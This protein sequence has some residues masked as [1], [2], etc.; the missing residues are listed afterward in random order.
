MEQTR[1]SNGIPMRSLGAT[2][3]LVTILG[4]GGYHIAKGLTEAEGIRIIRTAIDEGVN[5]LDN[6]WCYNDGQSERVMGKALQDG[7][8]DRVLLMTKNHGRDRRTFEEQLE[9][10]LCRLGTEVID[11]LQFHAISNEQQI[12]DIVSKGA[13]EA[14]LEAR[15]RGRIRYIGFTG[16]TSPSLHLR[17]LERFSWDTVQMPVNL[18]DYHYDSFS[19]QVLPVLRR[20]EIGAIA[21]K[22]LGGG[23][24]FKT[25]VPPDQ[26]IAWTLSQAIDSLVLGIDSVELLHHNLELVRTWE[27]MPAAQATALLE[28]VAP[29]ADGSLEH[30]KPKR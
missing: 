24:L 14:A 21:M 8:R 2:G 27:P 3:E 7:Y 26:A 1:R 4:I 20:R 17:M 23:D 16:H 6:A 18:L 13:L 29:V 25:D 22:S 9:E 30:Y 15:A 28:Q 10:S 12:H 5:F 11:V 19:Q